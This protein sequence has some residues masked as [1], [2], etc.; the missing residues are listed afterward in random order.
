MVRK[1]NIGVD[2]DPVCV[3]YN[4][5]N[6]TIRPD[7]KV[8]VDGPVD[9]CGEE[10]TK[11]PLKFGVVK[12]DFSCSSNNL[13]TLE[14]A[15]EKA[16]GGFYCF[17]N[18]LTSL[19]YAPEKVSGNFYCQYNNLT[20]LEYAPKEVGG[21]FYCSSN[22][23]TSLEYAPKEVGG[24]F[25]CFYNNLLDVEALVK[26][27]IGGNLDI[28]NNPI[29]TIIKDIDIRD[30]DHFYLIRPLNGNKLSRSLYDEV[31]VDLGLHEFDY[32]KLHK[33]IELVD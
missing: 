11:L 4:I 15:P 28:T 31:R 2:I 16:G 14:F 27:R 7:G 9:L 22:N 8:D 19:E 24:H 12:G 10:L 5:T 3:Q 1:Y 32:S 13:T 6:Y 17:S 33:D 18:K 25:S 21:D 20:S 23:L 26:C 30:L 29:S